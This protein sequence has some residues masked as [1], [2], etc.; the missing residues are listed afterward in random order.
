VVNASTNGTVKA[1]TAAAFP[2]AAKESKDVTLTPYGTISGEPTT[3]LTLGIVDWTK[4]MA[5]HV[6]AQ[7]VTIDTTRSC[8]LETVLDG[9]PHRK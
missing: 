7:G 9:G 8:V 5:G 2:I 3:T 1:Q 6:G 4:S